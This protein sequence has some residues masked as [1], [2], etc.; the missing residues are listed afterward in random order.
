MSHRI[1]FDE[2]VSK[3]LR[4][5]SGAMGQ[6]PRSI[7]RIS[8]F[9]YSFSITYSFIP[10]DDE[11]RL[12]SVKMLLHIMQVQVSESKERYTLTIPVLTAP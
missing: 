12:L 10:L 1:R 3:L 7:E 8:S 2:Q 6:I 5:A 4:K 11:Q 9:F